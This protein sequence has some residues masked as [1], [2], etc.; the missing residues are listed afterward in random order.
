MQDSTPEIAK[1]SNE[2]ARNDKRDSTLTILL[3]IDEHYD[4]PLNDTL[5]A[6]LRQEKRADFCLDLGACQLKLCYGSY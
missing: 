6:T 2:S 1:T 3:D 5:E 4:G